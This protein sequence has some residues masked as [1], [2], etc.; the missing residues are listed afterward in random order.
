MIDPDVKVVGAIQR[1]QWAEAK[2][3][4]SFAHASSVNKSVS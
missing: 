4:A 2:V 3:F 1:G